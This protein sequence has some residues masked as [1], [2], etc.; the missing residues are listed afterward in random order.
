MFSNYQL[1]IVSRSLG[2][3]RSNYDEYDLEALM[4]SESE[5]EAEVELL[6]DK[7][8]EITSLRSRACN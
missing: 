2:L 1:A 5:L 8:E 7:I 3:L 4:Y 6:Q